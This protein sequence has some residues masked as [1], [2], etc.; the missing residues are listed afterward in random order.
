MNCVKMHWG[1]TY[2]LQ[3]RDGRISLE[4]FRGMVEQKPGGNPPPGQEE[5]QG[6]EPEKE[7]E[8][9]GRQWIKEREGGAGGELRRWKEE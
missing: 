5:Q 7:K 8:G 9:A 3:D 1:V 4:E 6:V 2:F